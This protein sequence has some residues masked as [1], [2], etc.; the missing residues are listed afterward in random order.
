MRKPASGR[1]IP[2]PLELLCLKTLWQMGE[3]R[4][5]DVRRVVGEVRPLAYTTVMTI[6]ER[7]VRRG[8]ASRRKMGRSFVYAPEVSRES[9]RR[10]AVQEM[11]D[12]F[13]DG[14]PDALAAFLREGRP[15]LEET[16]VESRAA[17]L[18]SD[19]QLDTALL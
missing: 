1:Q 10:L 3:G 4:V 13:F 17:V 16:A 18:A 7:L 19:S 11:L 15:V 9:L 5:E 8:A 6:L 12:T 2:P 14:S